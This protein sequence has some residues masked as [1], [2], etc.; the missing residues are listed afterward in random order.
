MHNKFRIKL[1]ETDDKYNQLAYLQQYF[2]SKF[3]L[4]PIIGVELEFYLTDN[5]NIAILANKINY[6][7]KFEKGKNQYEIDF[8]PTQDLITIAKEIVLTRDIISD[9]AKDMG[10]LADFRSKPFI[11]DYGSS[12]HIHLNFLED[13]NIDKYAQILCSQL[14]QYL[15]YFLPTQEDY[16]RL[17]SKFMAPTHISW[18]GNNRSVLI[19]IPD[20][21]PKRIEH[22][23]ASSNTD[24]ALVI[25]AIMDGI[26]NGLENNE[27]IKHLP[28]IYGN[29]YDPQYNLQKIIR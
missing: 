21:L 19:R 13:N 22:R 11:D 26:K 29:A 1:S 12:M 7:I 28:K 16:E 3:N 15:N 24:P 9:I 18:G 5:I 27:E 17:D 4:T 6:Q 8:K 10:G 20:S 14:E 25:F 2:K 23:L